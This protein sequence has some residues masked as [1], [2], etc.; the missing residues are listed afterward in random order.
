[1]AGMVTNRHV[2]LGLLD[3]QP[4][5]GYDIRRFLRQFNWLIGSPS[6]GGLYP[7]L[8]GLVDAGLAVVEMKASSNGPTR[9][10]YSITGEGREVFQAWLVESASA[11]ISLR[12]FVLLLLLADN[13]IGSYERL[14]QNLE[15]RY[16]QV[17][18]QSA[19]LVVLDGDAKALTAFGNSLASDYSRAIAEAELAWLEATRRRVE[20]FVDD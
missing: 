15:Q 6:Y 10:L 14:L 5:S 4:M 2:L 13:G 18:A 11:E 12:D 3:R 17:A 16:A 8:H 19:S 1:M 20:R 7:A 9:K